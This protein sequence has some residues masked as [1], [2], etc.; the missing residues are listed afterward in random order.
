MGKDNDAALLPNK[1]L[2]GNLLPP[3]RGFVV[4]EVTSCG[5][6]ALPRGGA[7]VL[8]E[9]HRRRQRLED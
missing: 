6:G 3:V 5:D 8:L 2:T 4:T 9:F 1:Q 7:E